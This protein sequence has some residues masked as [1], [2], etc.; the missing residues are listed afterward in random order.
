M[1][2]DENNNR[3]LHINPGRTSVFRDK[4]REQRTATKPAR[5]LCFRGGYFETFTLRGQGE[6]SGEMPVPQSDIQYSRTQDSTRP[7]V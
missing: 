4:A 1:S 5:L 6:T 2:Q 3:V 7:T